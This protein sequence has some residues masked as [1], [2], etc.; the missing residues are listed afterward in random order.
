MPECLQVLLLFILGPSFVRGAPA[1]RRHVDG[2]G[3]AADDLLELHGVHH[4]LE[5]RRTP[6]LSGAS[7]PAIRSLKYQEM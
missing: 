1:D 3:A 7:C 6:S 5:Q 2:L 4:G